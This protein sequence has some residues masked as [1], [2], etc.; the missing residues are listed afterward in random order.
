MEVGSV[1]DVSEVNAASTSTAP[2]RLQQCPHPHG[3]TIQELN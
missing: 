3:V 2:K 1:A